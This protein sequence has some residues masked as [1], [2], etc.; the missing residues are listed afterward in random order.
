MA[1]EAPP[2]EEKNAL[3]GQIPE[4]A[5]GTVQDVILKDLFLSGLSDSLKAH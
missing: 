5:P 2:W 3:P 4:Y 1:G